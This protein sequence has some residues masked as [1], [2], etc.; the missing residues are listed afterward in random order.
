MQREKRETGILSFNACSRRCLGNRDMKCLLAG[1]SSWRDFR[2]IP[3]E[4]VQQATQGRH[5]SKI[6]SLR[7][8]A[9]SA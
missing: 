6:K 7:G 1:V 8:P 2:T 5:F 9:Y 3:S 4:L